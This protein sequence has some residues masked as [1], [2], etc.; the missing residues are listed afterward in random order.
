MGYVGCKGVNG[1]EQRRSQ[2]AEAE[3]KGMGV[4]DNLHPWLLMQE[5]ASYNSPTVKL[6]DLP[7]ECLLWTSW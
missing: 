1:G 7:H 5:P 3:A 4:Y 6:Q 2:Y